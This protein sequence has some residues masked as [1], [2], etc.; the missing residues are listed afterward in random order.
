MQATDGNLYGSTEIGGTFGNGL[1]FKIS[2]GGSYSLLYSFPG[3][4]GISPEAALLQHTNGVLYGTVQGGPHGDGAVY[5]LNMGLNP[6]ITFVLA[7]GRV[8]QKAQILGQG[9]TGA[10]GV[11]FN[12][13]PASSFSVASDT[14]MTA[15]VP[16][17]ASTGPVVIE[18]PN[19]SLTSNKNFRIT[20]AAAGTV[21]RN[22]TR[23]M[24][25]PVEKSN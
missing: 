5:S 12:G 22:S 10:T 9:L 19:G 7:T 16:A 13:V 14:Y 17:G 6:F 11:S 4:V 20:S 3:K 8:G 2:T 25:H 23:R 15:T 1:I 18:T 21:K 24:A